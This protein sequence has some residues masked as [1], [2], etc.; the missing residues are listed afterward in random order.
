M[1]SLL[2]AAMVLVCSHVAAVISDLITALTWLI[3]NH[4]R[5]VY[6]GIALLL[7]IYKMQLSG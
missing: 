6:R 5:A 1:A 7:L 3:I 2:D 4:V